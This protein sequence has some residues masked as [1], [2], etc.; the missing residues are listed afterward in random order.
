MNEVTTATFRFWTLANVFTFARFALA[1]VCAAF[2]LTDTYWGLWVG[3][4]A[5]G[6]AMF[7]DF[8][9]GY[10]A[11]RQKQVSDLGKIFDPL[12][13]AVF[14][15]IVWT[16]LALVGA[17]PIWFVLPFVVREFLQHVYIRPMAMARGVVLGANFW[18]KLKTLVQTLVLIALCWLEFFVHYWPWIAVWVKPLNMVLIGVTGLVSVLSIIPYF[19]ALRRA[20]NGV[21]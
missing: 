14:F 9:D 18:G 20:Q 15:I 13:D 7:T 1:P 11:R 19:E 3:G 21:N 12:A 8:C 10:F 17:Y 5:G 2:F 6:L 16:A 4:W